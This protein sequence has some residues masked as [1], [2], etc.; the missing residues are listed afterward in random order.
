TTYLAQLWDRFKRD[1]HLTVAAYH[2]GPT[3]VARLRRR[4]PQ[5]SGPE[6]VAR[7]AGPATRAYVR[8]VIRRYT[9]TTAD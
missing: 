9:K 3:R 4:H 6:L 1:P 7:F 5:L 2:M 8:K